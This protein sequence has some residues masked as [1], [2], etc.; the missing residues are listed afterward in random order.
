MQLTGGDGR[1]ILCNVEYNQLSAMLVAAGDSSGDTN[2]ASGYSPYP[3]N[4]NQLAVARAPA[5]P[6]P[7][8]SPNPSPSPGPDPDL[9]PDPG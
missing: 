7:I 8:P 1:G 3:G 9:D 4:T 6:N 5:S 2:D